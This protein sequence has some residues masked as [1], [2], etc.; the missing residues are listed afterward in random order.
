[1][2]TRLSDLRPVPRR[3][4]ECRLSAAGRNRA[5][6]ALTGELSIHTPEAESLRILLAFVP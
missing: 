4:S 3:C 2:V 5:P 6:K 1:M